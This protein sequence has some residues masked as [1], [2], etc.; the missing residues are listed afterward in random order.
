MVRTLFSIQVSPDAQVEL[1][2]NDSLII[3]H[4]IISTSQAEQ[5][6]LYRC[7]AIDGHKDP[8]CRSGDLPCI[9]TGTLSNEA[10]VQIISNALSLFQHA[11]VYKLATQ[12]QSATVIVLTSFLLLYPGIK[13]F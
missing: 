5:S 6:G 8:Y 2:S 3:S 7:L 10:R 1:F 11:I 12:T 9:P 13:L 4:L